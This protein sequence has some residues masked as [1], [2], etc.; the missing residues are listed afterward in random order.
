MITWYRQRLVHS[1]LLLVIAVTSVEGD[2][3][4]KADYFD[5]QTTCMSYPASHVFETLPVESSLGCG[6]LCEKHENCQAFTF[7]KANQTCQLVDQLLDADLVSHDRDVGN[8]ETFIKASIQAGTKD[9]T[10][11]NGITIHQSEP[12]PCTDPEF[13][14]Y[15][16]ENCLKENHN[17]V[18]ASLPLS[19][20][21]L[22]FLNDSTYVYCN[23]DDDGNFYDHR[24]QNC[25]EP[26]PLSDL[27]PRAILDVDLQM[28][29]RRMRHITC[30]S[31]VSS[32]INF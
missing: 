2:E 31:K 11:C 24:G 13:N 12:E 19:G 3:L 18:E 15:H 22:L 17:D 20:G 5:R 29:L 9:A 7:M 32:L 23:D 25:D 30:C 14:N 8:C 10:T 6:I 16:G 21:A 28:L 4:T 27:D 26:R 1:A